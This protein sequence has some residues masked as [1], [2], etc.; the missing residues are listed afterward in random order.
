MCSVLL[1]ESVLP[2]NHHAQVLVV[3]DETLDIQLL[4][5]DGSQLLAVHQETAITIDVYYHLQ[6]NRR[7]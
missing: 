1:V 3:H 5:E 6:C 2:L 7:F 4:Y